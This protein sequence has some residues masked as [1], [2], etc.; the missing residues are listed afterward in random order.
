VKIASA[1]N[2]D[3]LNQ[4]NVVIAYV[5]FVEVELTLGT[6]KIGECGS[7]RKYRQR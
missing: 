4:K 2:S 7:F 6:G 3:L 1:F 5:W